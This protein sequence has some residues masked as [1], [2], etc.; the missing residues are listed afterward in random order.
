MPTLNKGSSVYHSTYA[1]YWRDS[2]G[3]LL[4][5]EGNGSKEVRQAW[6]QLWE[7]LS[8]STTDRTTTKL[9]S[10]R[11]IDRFKIELGLPILSDGGRLE[12]GGQTTQI[13]ELQRS[14]G[15]T[16]GHV[17]SE[18]GNNSTNADLH[19][20]FEEFLLLRTE[21]TPFNAI[22][23]SNCEARRISVQISD[24]FD[25][26]LRNCPPNDQWSSG[27]GREYFLNRV[28]GFVDK[29][30]PVIFCLP[31]FPCK[32]SNP[33]KVGGTYPDAA[34]YYALVT[35]LEFLRAVSAIYK[36]GAI[37]WL[38][39]D[40]HVFSD[41][42]G[43]DDIK[44]DE[45]KDQLMEMYHE[46]CPDEKSRGFIRFMGLKDIFLSDPD[47]TNRL[48][49][50]WMETVALAHPVETVLTDDAELCRKLMT[51]MCEP[52]RDYLRKLIQDQ[53]PHALQLYRGLSRFMLG[54]LGS[55]KALTSLS[56]KQQKK[57]SSSVATE[58]ILRNQ[59]YSNLVELLFPNY[60]RLSIHAHDNRG[61]KF[62][63]NLFPKTMIRSIRSLETRHETQS[64]YDFHLP[65]PW[66]NSIIK[67]NGDE[68]MYVGRAD[69][70]HAGFDSP[71]FSGS[72]VSGPNG[73]HFSISSKEQPVAEKPAQE[74]YPKSGLFM[75]IQWV[76][77]GITKPFWT[78]WQ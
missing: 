60:V 21:F 67:V 20:W 34:E 68:Y 56:T 59:A 46:I 40:G 62:G 6:P 73:G 63:I 25:A 52:D 77:F 19:T 5:V 36:P 30:V 65:T 23:E 17:S 11:Q 37:L 38:I 42:I 1:L 49:P 3:K 53:E 72:W 13:R 10:G 14:N 69:I 47:L 43:V 15:L 22:S 75:F 35:M 70:A 50:A 26:K 9:P 12:S 18:Q 74:V 31:A 71:Q 57:L 64:S 66:H 55:H 54:D 33:Q 76:W 58:M 39:S 28:Y 24:L 7:E 4:A 45:Y 29:G 41:C 51:D 32:S 8:A 27:G 16:L 2:N 44:V 78:L 48:S 61:P